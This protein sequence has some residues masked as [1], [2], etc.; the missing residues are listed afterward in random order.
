[1]TNGTL[2]TNYMT[3]NNIT[4]NG[5]FSCGYASNLLQLIAGQVRGLENGTQIGVIDFSAH[6]RN[7]Q[8]GEQYQ[9]LQFQAQHGTRISSPQISVAAS[10]DINVI[11]TICQTST[12]SQPIISELHDN[13][14]GCVGWHYGTFRISHIDGLCTTY[15][16]VGTG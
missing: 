6:F 16:T 13:G 8:T 4:A 5:Q 9:G 2:K 1:M 7:V 12:I 14:N 3:A 15:S 11:A 10:S